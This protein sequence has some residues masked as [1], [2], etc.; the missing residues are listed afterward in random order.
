[1]NLHLWQGRYLGVALICTVL[2]ALHGC[3]DDDSHDV[4]SVVDPGPEPG[5]DPGPEPEPGP[6]LKGA[7][8][9]YRTMDGG[10]TWTT[11]FLPW[12]VSFIA[13]DGSGRESKLKC[14]DA[15]NGW[16]MGAD[17][18]YSTV[19]GGAT[20]QLKLSLDSGRLDTFDAVS[21]NLA[22]AAIRPVVPGHSVVLRTADGGATWTS[23]DLPQPRYVSALDFV[24]DSSGWCKTNAGLYH[25]SDGGATWTPQQ[26]PLPAGGPWI[27]HNVTKLAFVDSTTGWVAGNAGITMSDASGFIMKYSTENNPEGTWEVQLVEENPFERVSAVDSDH[28]WALNI[29]GLFRTQDG[30]ATW[31]NLGI[32]PYWGGD[33]GDNYYHGVD[34]LFTDASSGWM[35]PTEKQ[36]LSTSDGGESWTIRLTLHPHPGLKFRSYSF[37]SATTVW[38]V[39]NTPP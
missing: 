30:G 7:F 20:W 32:P 19:D 26:T 18:L 28:A 24:D 3:K 1:M 13:R 22:W 37:V 10:A 29:D 2:V 39:A 38:L 15:Q 34:F 23:S 25:S 11:S 27:Y 31:S 35:I 16:L 21:M 5:P 4:T 17:T 9:L 8:T 6:A 36:L 33:Y 12:W 14:F